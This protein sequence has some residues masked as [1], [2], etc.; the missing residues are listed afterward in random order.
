LRDETLV[1]G[2]KPGGNPILQFNRNTARVVII[3]LVT[4]G[5]DS[6]FGLGPFAYAG[7]LI[8]SSGSFF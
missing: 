1:T 7:S 3:G 4:I 2:H 5:A 6:F 8:V